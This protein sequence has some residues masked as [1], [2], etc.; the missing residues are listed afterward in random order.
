MD[1][2]AKA[3]VAEDVA[4]CGLEPA[5]SHE[6]SLR[7][8]LLRVAPLHMADAYREAERLQGDLYAAEHETRRWR[9]ELAKHRRERERL[10]AEIQYLAGYL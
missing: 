2:L 9:A 4:T 6:R 10:E 1:L 7:E 5:E 8:R 3:K